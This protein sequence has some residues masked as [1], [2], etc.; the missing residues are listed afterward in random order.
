MEAANDGVVVFTGDLGIYGN[1]VIIDHGLGLFTQ[2]SHMSSIA[3]KKG[4][5]VNENR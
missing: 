1:T 4:D 5:E 2:Y 3:V